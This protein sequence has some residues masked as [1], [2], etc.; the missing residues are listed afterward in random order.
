[1]LWEL[2]GRFFCHLCC[3]GARQSGIVVVKDHQVVCF[4]SGKSERE[5]RK[6]RDRRASGRPLRDERPHYFHG[7][8]TG[9]EAAAPIQCWLRRASGRCEFSTRLRPTDPHTTITCTRWQ[10]EWGARRFS[11]WRSSPAW[12]VSAPSVLVRAYGRKW[13]ACGHVTFYLVVRPYRRRSNNTPH[14]DSRSGAN[15]RPHFFGVSHHR[16]Y[17]PTLR[18]TPAKCDTHKLYFVWTFKIQYVYI[19]HTRGDSRQH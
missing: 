5:E 12:Q 7:A 8:H 3:R 11:S 9:D 1:M 4:S 18:N 17:L 6:K 19:H 15:K 2:A 10:W 14:T 13:S 16:S